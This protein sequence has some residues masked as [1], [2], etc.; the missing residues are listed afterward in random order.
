[1]LNKRII[2]AGLAAGVLGHILQ[3]I[4]AYLVFDRFYL[5]NVDLVRD[6]GMIVS[7]YYLALNLVVGLVIAYLSYYLQ[8][9]KSGADWRTGV[10]AGLIIWAASSPVFIIKRQIVLKLSNWLLLEIVADLIIYL[11]IGAA[12]GFLIGRGI[13]DE[14]E[15]S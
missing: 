9:L 8:K 7:F 13:I 5:E 10:R 11:V 14:M 12:A 1:M 2:W 4:G 6:S 3:G 15:P